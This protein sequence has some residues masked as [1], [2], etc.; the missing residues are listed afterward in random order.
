MEYS[1]RTQRI[2]PYLF[3][4]IDKAITK[5][6]AKGVD[7][8]SLG[9]GD[10]DLPTPDNIVEKLSES[11][12][13][14]ANQ[15]YPSYEGMPSFRTAIANWYKKRFNV[16]LNPEDEILTLI[17]SKEGI[18]HIP[19][20]FINPGDS[21][22][23]ANPGYPVYAIGTILADGV[24]EPLP[25]TEENDFK[26]D[27][28]EIKDE[29]AEKARIMH[30]NYPNNPTAAT[31]DKKFFEEAVSFANEHDIIV[32]HDAAYSEV[33]FDGYKAPSFLQ[34]DGAKN[35][36]IEFHSL[37][38]TYNMTGWR[39]GF[40]VGKKEV[41]AGLGKIKQNIDSGAF[42][43]IQEAGIEAVTGPQDEVGKNM[44][45][46]KE[47][48]DIMVKGLRSLGW[49]VSSPKATF[50]LWIPVPGGGSSIDFAKKVL[51]DA[52]VVVTPGVGFGEYGEGYIR[53]ALTQRK[54]RLKEAL[55]RLAK[56]K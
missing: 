18:A 23:C 13:N 46:I 29:T 37:S 49:N 22:L 8:I 30:I 10:P 7:V 35:V 39:L 38:K 5:Q 25:L 28:S 12:K 52:G 26:P 9:I 1:K 56:L 4:E 51:D 33:A 3:A 17:G 15:R 40:A 47:R 21:V 6:K 41:I 43:A 20:A 55:D 42:Q 44:E 53:I 54:E 34:V 11:S 14:P 19:L 36:G 32:C 16:E 24:P 45:T 27:F 2:P 48:R 50:Y 31:A